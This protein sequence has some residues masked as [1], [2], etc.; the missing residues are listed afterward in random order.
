[1]SVQRLAAAKNVELGGLGVREGLL[2][3]V[4]STVM[5]VPVAAVVAILS[6]VTLMA[7]EG[8]AFVIARRMW[9]DGT[10]SMPLG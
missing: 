9:H 5:P 1:M 6:R 8:I 10:R 4:L 2:T 7:A 3:A